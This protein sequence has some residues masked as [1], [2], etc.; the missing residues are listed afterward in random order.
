M[1]LFLSEGL[2]V[3]S[4][5]GTSRGAINEQQQEEVGCGSSTQ[6][7]SPAPAQ[8]GSGAGSGWVSVPL[9]ALMVLPEVACS[10]LWGTRWALA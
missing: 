5:C 7:R 10:A 4:C 9:D 3:T 6:V 8:W 2:L 1:S